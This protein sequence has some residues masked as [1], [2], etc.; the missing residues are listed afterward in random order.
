MTSRRLIASP[1]WTSDQDTQLERLMASGA[2]P[3]EISRQ[4][5][6][7]VAAIDNRARK[8]KVKPRSTRTAGGIE[9]VG[10]IRGSRA[11][12]ANEVF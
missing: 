1:P 8:L 11:G 7:T 10:R 6:R 9:L 2:S 3:A 12:P 5:S 4:L